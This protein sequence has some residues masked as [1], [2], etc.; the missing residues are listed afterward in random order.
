[1][2]VVVYMVRRLRCT[3]S[4]YRVAVRVVTVVLAP[5]HSQCF[6]YPCTVSMQELKNERDPKRRMQLEHE[7]FLRQQEEKVEEEFSTDDVPQQVRTG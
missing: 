6:A 7:F 4:I 5:L 2:R 1:M 3:D